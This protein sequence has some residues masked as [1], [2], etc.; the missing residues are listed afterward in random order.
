LAAAATQ[1]SACPG[2]DAII[3][4][5]DAH[6]AA[7]YAVDDALAAGMVHPDLQGLADAE[8]MTARRV[9]MAVPVTSQGKAA[10]AAHMADDG[11]GALCRYMMA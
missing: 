7:A 5:I 11:Y 8:F 4:K 3:S 6:Q 2:P 10:L 9:A 1:Q